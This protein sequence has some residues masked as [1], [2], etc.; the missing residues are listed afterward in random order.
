MSDD[1]R[2]RALLQHFPDPILTVDRDARVIAANPAAC[3]L[4][5]ASEAA[6][7]RTQILQRVPPE[8]QRAAATL[9]MRAFQGRSAEERISFLCDREATHV[10]QMRVVPIPQRGGTPIVTMLLRDLGDRERILEQSRRGA[11]LERTP[12][13]FVLT[14]DLFA[15]IVHAMGLENALGHAD[16]AW[17]GRD[18]RELLESG[19]HR[20][21]I[22][23]S[24]EIDL[25][26]VGSWAGVQLCMHQDGTTVPFHL[27]ATPRVDPDTQ[28]P[29]G[30]Y[31]SGIAMIAR[32]TESSPGMS[33]QAVE[34]PTVH[35]T[36]LPVAPNALPTVLVIEDDDQ[37]RTLLHRYLERAGYGVV[38]AK[39]GREGM[40]ILRDGTAVH[41]VVTD[42]KMADGSGGWLMAQMGYEFPPLLPRT[43]VISGEA[44][45]AAAAHVAVR[46][47]CPVLAKPFAAA[48]LLNT[49]SRLAS[50]SESAA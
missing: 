26:D 31:L 18:A 10:V 32:G 14:L 35:A 50:A 2:Y 8:E 49:L 5:G 20:D 29:L 41:F 34:S 13:Q 28:E 22:F 25:A 24:V 46:W 38:E 42:L 30:C 3:Q 33:H 1:D 27:F 23:A 48:D 19:P 6:L 47:K 16:D 39:S 37:M 12:G 7:L 43:I 9:L 21:A 40:R 11:H 4:F 36:L 44:D 45:G 15:R 17:A